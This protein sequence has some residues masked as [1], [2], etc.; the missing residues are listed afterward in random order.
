MPKL[1]TH[2]SAE[3]RFR[4]SGSGLVMRSKQGSSHLRR[5]KSKRVKRQYDEMVPV[6]AVDQKRIKALLPYGAK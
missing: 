3:R 5:H 4:I 2:K 1:K 6:A